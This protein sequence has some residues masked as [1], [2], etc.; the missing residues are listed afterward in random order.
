MTD[1]G[2]LDSFHRV[3]LAAVPTPLDPMP[4]LGS[5]IDV[6]NLWCKRDDL[7]GLAAGGNKA[8]KLEYL[9]AEAIET[10]VEAL[11]RAGWTIGR[12]DP[13][14]PQGLRED[15]LMP[16]QAAGLAALHG[17]AYRAGP[18]HFD[19]DVGAQIARGL[20][21]SGIEVAAA[22]EASFAIRRTT[23]AFLA[24]IDLLLCPTAPCCAWS[25]E[26]LGPSH[27]GGVEVPPRGHA[28]FTPFFN[29]ALTPAISLPCGHGRNG[30]PVGLQLIAR[31]GADWQVIK[32][33]Q[34]AELI[35][36][37]LNS[38]KAQQS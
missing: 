9:M 8:R 31:R 33:A 26:R 2:K 30:L 6:Q 37:Q 29:H 1:A 4:T 14:W 22:L 34:E 18:H 28:V 32:A 24:D 10:G 3:P 25:V 12:K 21:L 5:R 23:A 16:L 19:P 7:T 17:T 20:E 11:R 36:A 38:T 15:S 35:L 13:V 27:I